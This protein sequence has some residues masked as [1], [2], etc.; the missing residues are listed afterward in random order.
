M[1]LPDKKK[2]I[3]A[4]MNRICLIGI[5]LSA[6]FGGLLGISDQILR[7]VQSAFS[8]FFLLDVC[9]KNKGKNGRSC[10]LIWLAFFVS[11]MVILLTCVY[12]SRILWLFRLWIVYSYCLLAQ[13]VFYGK[14]RKES[15]LLSV[16]ML[17]IFTVREWFSNPFV[18]ALLVIVQIAM[19]LRMIDPILYRIAMEH[20]KK[21]EKISVGIFCVISGVFIFHAGGKSDARVVSAEKYYVSTKTGNDSNAGTK[22]NAPLKTLKKAVSA[23]SDGDTVYVM[24]MMRIQSN[25]TIEKGITIGRSSEAMDY[26]I[27]VEDGAKLSLG[28]DVVITGRKN[29]VTSKRGLIRVTKNATLVLKGNAALKNNMTDDDEGR[30]GAVVN[31]GTTY[32]KGSAL[33][34]GNQTKKSGGG[35]VYN[36]GTI[37]MS[38]G[39]IKNNHTGSETAYVNEDR[40]NGG[41]IS[42]LGDVILT[43]GK[44]IGNYSVETGGGIFCGEG[45]SVDMQA[46]DVSDNQAYIRGGAMEICGG[47]LKLTGGRIRANQAAESGGLHV[48]M[49]SDHNR[50]S[51]F[52]MNGGTIRE[53]QATGSEALSLDGLAGGLYINR[54]CSVT[55]ISGT[56]AE[57]VSAYAGGGIFI[58]DQ[59]EVEIRSGVSITANQASSNGG[60]IGTKEG[61]TLK[62]K[63]CLIGN[64]S[65]VKGG[66]IWNK[67]LLYVE[68]LQLSENEAE[69]GRGIFLQGEMQLDGKIEKC[70]GNEVYLAKEKYIT[71]ISLKQS[72]MLP[73]EIRPS[74][75]TTG[76]VCVRNADQSVKSS[77]YLPF[78]FLCPKDPYLFRPGDKIDKSAGVKP[79]DLVVSRTYAIRYEKNAEN[80]AEK[81]P[82]DQTGYWMEVYKIS[83]ITPV[84]NGY[85]HFDEWNTAADK[86]KKTYLPGDE[87]KPLTGKVVLYAIWG[88]DP[89]QILAEPSFSVEDEWDERITQAYLKSLSKAEDREEGDLT[90]RIEIKNWNELIGNIRKPYTEEEHS[91]ACRRLEVI[92]AVKDTGGK[93]AQIKTVLTIFLIETEQKE[94]HRIRFISKKYVDSVDDTSAWAE[95]ENRE[96]LKSVLSEEDGSSVW[97]NL[98]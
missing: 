22:K 57:N 33:I 15:A 29:L 70:K 11:V 54:G 7:V 36:T 61:A 23:A 72:E 6:F 20:R 44:I 65:A 14:I 84:L 27:S 49:S 19:I 88:N 4:C 52:V 75:Y 10:V 74:N 86:S 48:T 67:G 64:N 28:G 1:D 50:K 17:V 24:D 77:I 89:P 12:E 40:L 73:I 47:S 51:T 60:G 55:L 83:S 30:G 85:T 32:I 97:E 8:V 87:L 90:A 78:F 38:G 59:C 63:G 2:K 25:M 46:G 35:A 92:Y 21:M 53:N 91:D 80:E 31:Y 42:N 34:S 3:S 69:T 95:E 71:L 41:G 94:S 93:T 76:R 58:G 79:Y 62:L 68:S 45:A 56:L 96:Y 9:L 81:F 37:Y 82:E 98:N 18:T 13:K 66:G 5:I 39:S 43:G 26:L 16:G